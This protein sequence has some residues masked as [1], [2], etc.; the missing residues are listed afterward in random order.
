MTDV[1]AVFSNI[2]EVDGK[3]I[4]S[5]IMAKVDDSYIQSMED[6][7]SIMQNYVD[8]KPV[9]KRTG[10]ESIMNRQGKL[11]RVTDPAN[12]YIQANNHNAIFN[13][14][15]TLRWVSEAVVENGA[16]VTSIDHLIS[17]MAGSDSLK[18]SE[19][20]KEYKR[21]AQITD[22]AVAPAG[23]DPELLEYFNAWCRVTRNLNGNL[24]V[25]SLEVPSYPTFDTEEIKQEFLTNHTTAE[26]KILAKDSNIGTEINSIVEIIESIGY[27]VS[28]STDMLYKWKRLQGVSMTL[29]NI[30]TYYEKAVADVGIVQVFNANTPPANAPD[31]TKL[32]A[33][34][35]KLSGSLLKE[36][37]TITS[38][39]AGMFNGNPD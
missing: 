25:Y 3:S 7:I 17:L 29:A 4:E 16:D 1:Y 20:E 38:V 8:R 15:C 34:A 28:R 21:Y 10:I 5:R 26:E 9:M 19:A 14:T 6:D 36:K 22:K 27:D 13:T 33:V 23:F 24:V 39:Q 18:N 35:T 12:E 37:G 31:D 11:E 2:T 30:R 32:S